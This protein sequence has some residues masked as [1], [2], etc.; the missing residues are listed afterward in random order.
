[1]LSWVQECLSTPFLPSSL[2]PLPFLSFAFPPS[3]SFPSLPSLPSSFP[4]LPLT[5]PLSPLDL[6]DHKLVK[7]PA[8]SP[9]MERGTIVSWEKQEG[10][11]IEEG[12]VLALVETDKAT[13]DM[14]VPMDGY[15]AT[16]LVTA[17]SKHMP[18]GKVWHP[19]I[20]CFLSPI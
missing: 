9:T 17:G 2:P 14:D 8:L 6:P 16:I 15:L 11:K 4:L 13:M 12:D 19:S 5:S 18:L 1:M 20:I 10:Q 7:L 3:F